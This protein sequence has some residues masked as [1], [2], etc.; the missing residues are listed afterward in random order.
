MMIFQSL[1]DLRENFHCKLFSSSSFS[2]FTIRKL[3]ARYT[4]VYRKIEERTER[5]WKGKNGKKTVFNSSLP[6]EFN[7]KT[8]SALE[9]GSRFNP[10]AI[11]L[12]YVILSWYEPIVHGEKHQFQWSNKDL[13]RSLFH[14]IQQLNVRPASNIVTFNHRL[15]ESNSSFISLITLARNL[16]LTFTSSS[17]SNVFITNHINWLISDWA[18]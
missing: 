8:S 12:A 1:R 11:G 6:L 5:A 16:W 9:A 3:M 7:T 4:R 14:Q 13:I 2:V 10:K 17:L 18:T 15:A